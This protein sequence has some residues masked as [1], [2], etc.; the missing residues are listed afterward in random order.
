MTITETLLHEAK[1]I[2]VEA[3]EK[4]REVG[5]PQ[6]R[7]VQYVPETKRWVV[8]TKP[9]VFTE[10]ERVWRLGVLLLS[11]QGDWFTAGETTRAVAPGHPG[12][13]SVERERRRDL[14]R[15]AYESNFEEGAVLYFNSPRIMLAIGDTPDPQSAIVMIDGELRV[16]W[17]RALHLSTARP[18]HTYVKEQVE[19]AIEQHERSTGGSATF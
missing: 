6:H 15:A 17:N 16:R 5:V 10:D 12:H 2:A 19:L 7:I 13:V 4:L 18:L 11:E 8:F 1:D 9:A 14:T 3:A